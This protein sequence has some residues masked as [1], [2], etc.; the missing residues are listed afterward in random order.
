MFPSLEIF[1][2]EDVLITN[3][4]VKRR[5]EICDDSCSMGSDALPSFVMKH[6][7]NILSPAICIL[8]NSIVFSCFWPSE[9]KLSNVTPFYKS[10]S[11]SDIT[12]YQ[13]ISIL[14]KMSMIFERI[15]FDFI[16]LI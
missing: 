8:F 13:S 14:P 11:S 4:D 12:Y 10:R 3:A 1:H 2:L 9:W 16:Y 6:C 15:L 7:F 5:L